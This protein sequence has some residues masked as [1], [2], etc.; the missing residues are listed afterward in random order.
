MYG[1]G[2]YSAM[3]YGNIAGMNGGNVHQSVK[4]KYGVGYEDFG[5]KPYAQPYPQA[6]ILREPEKPLPKTWIG[7]FLQKC[8]LG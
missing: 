8:F 3:G 4:A 6:I 5:G 7:R 1:I 2:M